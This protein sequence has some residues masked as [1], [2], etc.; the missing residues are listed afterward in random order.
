[1]IVA[2]S[3][4]ATEPWPDLRHVPLGRVLLELGERHPVDVD[5]VQAW[6]KAVLSARGFK[7][8]GGPSESLI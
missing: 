5:P 2:Q 3:D 6:D 4:S 1:M 7:T 8:V